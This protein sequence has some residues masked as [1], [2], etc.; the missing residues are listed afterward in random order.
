[1]LTG[2]DGCC[3]SRVAGTLCWT[4]MLRGE[5]WCR[6]PDSEVVLVA[7]FKA[8]NPIKCDQVRKRAR[9]NKKWTSRG[10][11]LDLV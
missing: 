4:A 10:N 9:Q 1:M 7:E 3:V 6:Y 5:V 2:A 11:F 8:A